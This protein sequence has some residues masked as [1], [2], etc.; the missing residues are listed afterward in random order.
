M[1]E[2]ALR[3]DRAGALPR[4][5]A[6]DGLRGIAAMVVVVYHTLRLSPG[7][8]DGI[9]SFS[10]HDAV[11]WA[12]TISPLRIIFDGTFAVWLF[13]GLSGFVLSR[14]Y[15]NGTPTR[16]SR[17]Y[18]RRIVR[19]YV[20][21]LGSALVAV[22]F[23]GIQQA[24]THTGHTP[25]DLG[26][27]GTSAGKLLSN[28]TLLA[29]VSDPLN[30][31]WWSMRWEVWYSLLLP[32]L[33][34]VL[35]ICG[36]GPRR[37][38]R[39]APLVFG[40]LCVVVIG[41]QPY[42]TSVITVPDWSER[43]MLYLPIFGI[44]M[45]VAAF[46][47]PIRD[48]AWMNRS[49]RG[50]VTLVIVVAVVGLRGPVGVLAAGGHLAPVVARGVIGVAS[51][52][53]A[54]G[55]IALILGWAPGISALSTRPL[56]WAGARSY[57]LYLVHLPVLHL[58]VAAFSLADASLLTVAGVLG[59]SLVVAEGFYRVVEGPSIRLTRR[60]GERRRPIVAVARDDVADPVSEPESV[61][62]GSG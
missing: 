35:A 14:M 62:V 40:V 54:A 45:V 11:S 30:G 50:W 20:P 1:T 4:L 34:V 7:F 55:L 33:M 56:Q 48:A 58:A 38:W 43:A 37:R 36:C 59:A 23:L 21:V 24:V 6:L 51:V 49:A 39:P 32:P 3:G 61:V 16:W 46:E 60:I 8:Y 25:V 57:S 9:F 42:L 18:P 15:W 53:G 10:P 31:V 22:V 52:L 29:L 13:F 2:R 17:Y 26:A 5:P 12:M 41:M 47:G 28:V 27:A 44:G 19:L